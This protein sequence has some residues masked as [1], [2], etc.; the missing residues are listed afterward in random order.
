MDIS[1]IRIPGMHNVENYMAAIAATE[2]LVSTDTIR[3]VAENFGGVEHRIEFVREV[4][5][6]KF[7]NDSIASTPARTTAGLVSCNQK[8]ILIAGGYDKKIPFDDFGPIVCE[9]VKHLILVGKT[10]EKIKLAVQSSENYKD[11]P[12][13]MFTDFEEAVSY[14][15]TV[16]EEGDIVL[17]SPACASFDLF[18]NFEERGKR[19]KEIV[20]SF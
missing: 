19:F 18:K 10:S 15:K 5:G 16:A 12:I 7:Y 4:N 6:I 3:Y 13:N 14:S 11:L 20:K 1:S 17:L 2:G 8:V 9:H